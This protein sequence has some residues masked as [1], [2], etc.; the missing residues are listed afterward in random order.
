[1]RALYWSGI[2]NGILAP[3]LLVGILMVSRDPVIMHGQPSSRLTQVTVGVTALA[4]FGAA[5]AMFVV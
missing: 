4:M 2:I 5:I 1:V 3:F